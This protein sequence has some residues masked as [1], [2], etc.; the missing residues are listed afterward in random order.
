[1]TKESYACT[2]CKQ[3]FTRKYNAVRHNNKV[4][5]G[6]AVIFNK[7]TGWISDK[8]NMI[9]SSSNIP[10][11]PAI[12][13]PSSK[14]ESD[15]DSTHLILDQNHDNSKELHKKRLELETDYDKDDE[16]EQMVFKIIGKL[17][18][19]IDTLDSLL[20]S[21][22]MGIQ[23]RNQLLAATLNSSLVSLDPFLFIKEQIEFYR[24]LISMRRAISLTSQYYNIQPAEAK[25][26][27]RALVLNSPYIRDLT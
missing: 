25:E 27:L 17:S 24:S 9:T 7:E 14:L 16:N 1:M 13:K 26:T 4:H 5:N 18:P 12:K 19:Y 10:A 11:K 20:L 22:G 3:T 21:R 2:N 15:K 6:I 23:E 8:R